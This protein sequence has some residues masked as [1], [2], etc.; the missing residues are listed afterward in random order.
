MPTYNLD[1][2][3]NIFV[4]SNSTDDT[5]NGNGG[6]DQL[7]GGS[8]N[9]TINGGSGND[10]ITGGAGLDTLTGGTG[11]DIFRDTMA[12][13][14][15]DHIT[16]FSI[17]DSIQITD[18]TT[19]NFGLD[20]NKIT[21]G[22]G[23]FVTVD[24]LG[25]GRLVPFALQGGGFELKLEPDARND[26][27]GDGRSDILWRDDN[28]LLT[29]WVA[30][31]SGNFTPNG[32][33][34][35]ANVTTDWHVVGT[36]DFNGDG[37][38]DILWRNDNGLLTNWLGNANGGFNPNSAATVGV[39]SDWTVAAVGDFNGDGHSD[40]L[41]RQNTGQLTDWLG[42]ANGSFTSNS[43]TYSEHVS[44]DWAVIASGD[45]NGDGTDDILWRQTSTGQL[46]DWLGTPNG[47][48]V[49]NS[50]NFSEHVATNWNVIATGDF[51][52]DGIDDILWREN[53][54]QLTD[55]LGTASGG[56][57]QN[58]AHFSEFVPTNWQV[59]S[60]GDFNGD[61]IDDILWRENGGQ[62]TDWLGTATGGF[63]QNSA[64]F[65]QLVATNWHVQDTSVHLL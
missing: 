26:F 65:S 61:G 45:F 43:A 10:I 35:F 5:I 51:N 49:Q 57:T 46:T 63:T 16:D 28:G 20:G 7:T 3:S 33:N 54:G 56:F 48:F 44:T 2:N 15:G 4:D 55:W 58:S 64:H 21:F 8:G 1:D 47:G 31:S 39:S 36:G 40:I 52:G 53:G 11:A 13:L 32:S 42:S 12:G 50:P 24:G 34:A 6:N 37:H 38:E 18:L 41:W 25:P 60:V 14:N 9:D 27:N 30:N 17:G 29:D 19:A 23:D 62:L 59:I 22:N